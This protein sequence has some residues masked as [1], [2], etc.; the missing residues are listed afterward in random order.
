VLTFVVW[1]LLAAFA[2]E[3]VVRR[4]GVGILGHCSFSV[5]IA[6]IVSTLVV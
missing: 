6:E 5:G 1:L 2:M 4:D 3:R